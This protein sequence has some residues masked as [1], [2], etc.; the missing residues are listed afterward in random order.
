MP[1]YVSSEPSLSIF[2]QEIDDQQQE[3]FRRLNDF[4]SSVV[5][6]DGKD[7][8]GEILNFSVDYSVVYF[9]DEEL[10]MQKS[11]YPAYSKHKRAH[12]QFTSG[13]HLH[14]LAF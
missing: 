6:G 7:E 9:G 4:F 13:E 5:G 2:V 10:Y 14:S 11:G 12:E 8:V 3:S 1:V